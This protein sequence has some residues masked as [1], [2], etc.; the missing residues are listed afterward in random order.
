MA[1]VYRSFHH[2]YEADAIAASLR[3]SACRIPYLFTSQDTHKRRQNNTKIF[4]ELTQFA[5]I[6]NIAR[7]R[8]PSVFDMRIFDDY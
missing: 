3:I 5:K 1:M 7:F 8:Q 4:L 2:H 6:R